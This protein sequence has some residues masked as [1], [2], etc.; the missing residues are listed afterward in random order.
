MPLCTGQSVVYG[1]PNCCS[2][3][4]LHS[5]D[6]PC[7]VKGGELNF[8]YLPKNFKKW[9]YDAGADLLKKGGRGRYFSYLIFSRF[10][11]FTFSNYVNP[12][13]YCAMHLKKNYFFLLV[14]RGY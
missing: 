1:T 8:K 11:I 5:L 13:K 10:I 12:L 7:F 9:N 2:Y 14:R 6:P 4:T 3:N